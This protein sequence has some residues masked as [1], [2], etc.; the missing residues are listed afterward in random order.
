VKFRKW[1]SFP[2]NHKK[3]AGEITVMGHFH[4]GNSDA[5]PK[6][7]HSDGKVSSDALI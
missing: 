2:T 3:N 5:I 7:A 4:L 1:I 6:E